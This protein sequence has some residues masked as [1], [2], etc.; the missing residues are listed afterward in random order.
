DRLARLSLAPAR[1]AIEKEGGGA[2]AVAL[3]HDRC[4]RRPPAQ[5]TRRYQ[6]DRLDD[7]ERVALQ[8]LGPFV[9]VE[10][11]RPEPARLGDRLDV[12]RGVVPE[13]ADRRDERWQRPNDRRDLLRRH[14]ARRTLH[15]DE[16]EGVGARLDGRQRVFETRDPTDLH[17]DH[18]RTIVTDSPRLRL[19]LARPYLER[20][21]ADPGADV[22][23][24]DG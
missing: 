3:G 13:D 10:L 6:L 24:R 16:P 7:R 17:A 11:E 19:R 4:P 21:L 14:E 1:R 23:R 2:V 22:A 8:V 15:E 12:A 5:L 9:A 20:Q 18:T